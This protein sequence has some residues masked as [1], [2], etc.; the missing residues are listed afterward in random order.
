MVT[1]LVTLEDN[2][3]LVCHQGI[4]RYRYT[5][6]GQPMTNLL[7]YKAAVDHAGRLHI[8]VTLLDG[9]LIYARWQG[10]RWE[11]SGLPMAGTP[12]ALVLDTLGQPHLLLTESPGAA[13][14]HLYQ[15]DRRWHQKMLPLRLV[16][17]PLLFKPLPGG[18]L[19]LAGQEGAKGKERMLIAIYDP[20]T[21]WQELRVAWEVEPVARQY[22]FWYQGRLYLLSW[23][24][25]EADYRLHLRIINPT[26]AILLSL[27]PGTVSDLPDDQPVLLGQGKAR[28]FLWT[29]SNCLTY[30][31]S[32]DGGQ[33]W[34]APQRLYAFYPAR[35]K[36]VE[37]PDGPSTRQVTFTKINGLDLDWPL[38]I[39]IEPLISLCRAVLVQ[40]A[41]GNFNQ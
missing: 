8:V 19:L 34:L 35:I 30:C 18:R 41:D 4:L 11:S 29:A 17:P 13:I 2:W 40:Q 9:R 3:Q 14:Y 16:A 31:L 22:C 39:S 23:L 7:S 12:L 20:A 5:A 6:N 26:G 37:G 33:S 38:V 36:R 25:R 1:F 27:F 28:L 32:R 24:G 15:R 21:A 10:H